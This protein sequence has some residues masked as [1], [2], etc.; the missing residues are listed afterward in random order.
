MNRL[1]YLCWG[2]LILLSACTTSGGQTETTTENTLII[3]ESAV[4]RIDSTLQAYVNDSIVAGASALIY[5]KGK[6]VYFNAFGDSDRAAGTPMDRNTIVQIFSMTKPVTGVALMTLY[7]EGKFELDDPL[8]NYAPEFADMQVYAG[9]DANGELTFEPTV[10]EIT[11]RDLTRHT[12]GFI[13]GPD[14]PKLAELITQAD[15]MNR[16][17]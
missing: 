15:P 4:A 14:N 9:E 2:T 1:Y 7:E 12:A 13:N 16:K 3:N 10:R 17:A 5:E 6:E 11:V 8:S